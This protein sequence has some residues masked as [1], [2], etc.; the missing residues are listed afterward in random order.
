[1][2]TRYQLPDPLCKHRPTGRVTSGE[3]SGA[4]A[5]VYVCGRAACVADAMAWAEASTGRPA[6]LIV[7]EVQ[8]T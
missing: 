6:V 2:N 8:D 4:H 3:L 1:M 5:S 7:R